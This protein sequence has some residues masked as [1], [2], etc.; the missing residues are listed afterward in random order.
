[1]PKNA[2]GAQSASEFDPNIRPMLFAPAPNPFNHTTS[3]RY[4]SNIAG[5]T[6]VAIHDVTGRK[7]CNLMAGYQRP[8]IYSVTWTGRDDRQRQ[9]PEGVYFV[10]L[11]TPNFAQSKKLL[12]MQ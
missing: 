6:S 3:I 4:Q 7:V 5:R 8:G 1:L 12:L 9:L 11:Q 10:R 2:G